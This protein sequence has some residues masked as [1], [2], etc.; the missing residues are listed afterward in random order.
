MKIGD[1]FVKEPARIVIGFLDYNAKT[2]HAMFACDIVATVSVCRNLA[3]DTVNACCLPRILDAPHIQ[4]D[5]QWCG[6]KDKR[7]KLGYVW[8]VGDTDMAAYQVRLDRL[9]VL[10]RWDVKFL[11]LHEGE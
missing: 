10:K 5:I 11:H 6:P 1:V 3:V 8:T 2:G 7:I 9:A 4:A